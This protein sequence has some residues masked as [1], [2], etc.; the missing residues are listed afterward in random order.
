VQRCFRALTSLVAV[1]VGG[2]GVADVTEPRPTQTITS[3]TFSL[4]ASTDAEM[5]HRNLG[6]SEEYRIIDPRLGTLAEVTVS[7]ASEPLALGKNEVADPADRNPRLIYRRE[8]GG[9]RI[10]GYAWRRN[11]GVV[12]DVVVWST[13]DQSST[14]PF[15]KEHEARRARSDAVS[16][17]LRP[18][19]CKRSQVKE[20]H[21]V[22]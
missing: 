13:I 22:Q 15:P 4:R 21:P 3:E 16:A 6:Y 18:T 10:I 19:S 1:A 2:C 14:T 8:Y 17:S 20:G 11:C 7:P 12:L 5:L 9:R